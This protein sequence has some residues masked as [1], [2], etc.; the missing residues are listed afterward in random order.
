MRTTKSEANKEKREH[1]CTRA[2]ENEKRERE[3]GRDAIEEDRVGQ[4]VVE[5]DGGK[6]G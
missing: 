3:R 6:A 4:G 5:N 2:R 1:A